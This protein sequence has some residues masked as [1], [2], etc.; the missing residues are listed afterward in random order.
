MRWPWQVYDHIY[1]EANLS[2]WSC[3][4][5]IEKLIS[6]YGYEKDVFSF[7]VV[8]EEPDEEADEE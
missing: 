8:A 3:I 1:F 7:N 2:A 5:F 6:E 4:R